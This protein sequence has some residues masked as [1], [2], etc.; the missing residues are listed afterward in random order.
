VVEE[1]RLCGLDGRV[2]ITEEAAEGGQ[3]NRQEK[4]EGEE[5]KTIVNGLPVD[6]LRGIQLRRK[7]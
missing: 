2:Q 6:G 1:S 7:E 4:R 5:E 3:N